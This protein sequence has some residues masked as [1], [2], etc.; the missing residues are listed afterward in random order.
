MHHPGE[1]LRPRKT[2]FLRLMPQLCTNTMPH[3]EARLEGDLVTVRGEIRSIAN[4]V[5]DS[6]R[7]ATQAFQEHDKE[8]AADTILRDMRVNRRIRN[9][10]ADCHAFVARHWPGARHLRFVSSVLRVSVALERIGDYA[11]SICR[12]TVQL[13]EACDKNLSAEIKGLLQDSIQLLEES[14][15]VFT[16]RHEGDARS[17]VEYAA[18]MGGRFNQAFENL[19]RIGETGARIRDLM[20]MLVILNRV[21]R[22]RA[23]AK[24]IAEEALFVHTGETK[25]PK[26]Y[27]IL[28]VDQ[29][30]DL[31][32]PLAQACAVKAFPQ[33]GHYETAGVE[34]SARL[35]NLVE[36]LSG[37][38]GITIGTGAPRGLAEISSMESFHVIVVLERLL[39][40]DLGP[41]SFHTVLV[42]W[43]L[44]P[45]TDPEK[46]LEEIAGRLNTLMVTMRGDQAS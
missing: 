38:H 33:S 26:V 29:R 28:F 34:P 6:L 39:V 3:Y 14:I 44:D 17:V 13:E 1:R 21:S 22:V 15:A 16:D 10:D 46:L 11:A 9:L 30:N 31:L 32:G 23:Q 41:P 36:E 37:K 20:A 2:L 7:S 4:L 12:E 24:N 42:N 27:K 5:R 45:G 43:N 40:D 18:S 8:L 25:A 35:S 19:A